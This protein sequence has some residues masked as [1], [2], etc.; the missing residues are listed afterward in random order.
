M[1]KRYN[2]LCGFAVFL[3][4]AAA[5]TLTG[6]KDLSGGDDDDRPPIAGVSVS[7]ATAS[8]ARG[9]T[10][11]FTAAVS[12][13][14]SGTYKTVAWS[15]EPSGAAAGTAVNASGL[16]TVAANE[17]LPTL[18]VRATSTVDPSKS[19]AATVTVT[20]PALSGSVAIPGFIKVGQEATANTSGLA[21]AGAISYS[22]KKADAENGSFAVISN[23]AANKY[24]PAATDAGK[25][26]R[27]T[28]TRA[29]YT[30]ELSSPA[31]KVQEQSAA[32]PTITNVAV[33]PATTSVARGGSRQFTVTV[34]GTDNAAYQTVAWSIETS[35]AAAGT[36]IDGTGRLTVASDETLPTLTVKAA[37]TI[38]PGKSGTATVTV[39]APSYHAT[40]GLLSSSIPYTQIQSTMA[41]QNWSIADSGANWAL[42]TGPA[43]IAVQNWCYNP[44]NI[45]YDLWRYNGETDGSFEEL[46]NY[47]IDGIGIPQEIKNSLYFTGNNAPLMVVFNGGSGMSN[48]TLFI[49]IT[50]N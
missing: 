32:A 23:A 39:T 30:G 5:F 17:T 43:A 9:G 25:W 44:S 40:W 41:Q 2:R 15:I 46:K 20:S 13:T 7:P 36:F 16:L 33:N 26:L 27:V 47:S 8:V 42:A 1:K 6:C 31:V 11:Q 21:G 37:S 3:F 12:G 38:D 14:D 24:T 48:R 22:W 34:S 49:Y 35:G 29:E 28:V 18:I 10:R 45:P 50:R 19:G 4:A